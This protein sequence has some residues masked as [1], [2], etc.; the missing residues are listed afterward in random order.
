MGGCST[1]GFLVVKRQ[2]LLVA[3]PRRLGSGASLHD[4]RTTDM[5][6]GCCLRRHMPCASRRLTEATPRTV[7]SR[8]HDV[9]GH[10]VEHRS[11]APWRRPV[12]AHLEQHCFRR[13]STHTCWT[14]EASGLVAEPRC[15]VAR[16]CAHVRDRLTARVPFRRE[17]RAPRSGHPERTRGI[18]RSSRRR[19]TCRHWFSWN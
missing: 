18:R 6:W 2:P 7:S 13:A 16:A 12:S 9:R 10:S 15:R 19:A 11:Y 4:V 8:P 1:A 14:P 5:L 3:A 17:E